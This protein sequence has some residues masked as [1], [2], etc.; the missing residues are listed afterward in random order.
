MPSLF[1]PGDRVRTC[2]LLRAAPTIP[3]GTAGTIVLVFVSTPD[4]Y[5]VRFD[6]YGVRIVSG[7]DLEQVTPPAA[8]FRVV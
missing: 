6:G 4:T 1:R 2:R 3:V 8:R 5:L 7:G